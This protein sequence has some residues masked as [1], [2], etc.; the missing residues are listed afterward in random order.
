M[1]THRDE[2]PFRLA[3]DRGSAV[4]RLYERA[5]FA[6]L[7]DDSSGVDQIFGTP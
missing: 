6:Y 3:I 4:Q 2:R 5:G 1:N 7:Y